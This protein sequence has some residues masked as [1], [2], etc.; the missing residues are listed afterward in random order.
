MD[1]PR[2]NSRP[3]VLRPDDE[4]LK[5]LFIKEVLVFEV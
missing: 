4:E 3:V 2:G 5:S 1:K